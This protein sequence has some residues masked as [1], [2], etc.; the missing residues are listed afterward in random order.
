MNQSINLWQKTIL[1]NN[2][3]KHL[4]MKK[5]EKKKENTIQNFQIQHLNI[6]IVIKFDAI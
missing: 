6:L 2:E 5:K 4:F 3:T 1:K